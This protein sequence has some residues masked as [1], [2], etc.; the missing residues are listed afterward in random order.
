MEPLNPEHVQQV[1]KNHGLDIQM[2]FFDKSTATS[3]MAA[4]EIG[5]QLGQIVKSIAF[6]VNG[7]PLL[8][9][10]S[11]DQ[12]VDDRKI[13]SLC[14][15]GRKKVR[16]ATPEQCVEIFGYAPGGVPPFGHR[17]SGLTIYIDSSLQR[18]DEL[19]AAG[20]A[21]NA[22]FPIQLETLMTLSGGAVADIVQD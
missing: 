9:L 19:F 6:M 13:A 18:F 16:I 20:G 3:Q 14:D 12:R 15:V 2:T 10:T 8:A 22:I 21:H 4:D 1:I 7:D 11:G 5:C 17:Q